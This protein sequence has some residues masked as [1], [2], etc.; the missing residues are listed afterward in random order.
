[1]IIYSITTIVKKDV[2]EEWLRWMK[3][4]HMQE[5]IQTGYFI[6]SKMFK[7]KVPSNTNGETTYIIQYYC[8]AMENYMTYAEK[9]AKR[10]QAEYAAKF[11]GRVTTARTVMEEI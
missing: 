6:D 7:V 8:S 11:A 3:E 10:L 5:I 4:K 2:E 1:M 9:E